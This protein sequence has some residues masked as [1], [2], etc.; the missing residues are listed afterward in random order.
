MK[1]SILAI[2]TFASLSMSAANHLPQNLENNP[3]NVEVANDYSTYLTPSLLQSIIKMNHADLLSVGALD[4]TEVKAI[5]FQP[6]GWDHEF[7]YVQIMVH[8][9]D[10]MESSWVLFYPNEA[11]ELSKDQYTLIDEAD[12]PCQFCKMMSIV[13][14]DEMLILGN[15]SDIHVEGEILSRWMEY[16]FSEMSVWWT[17]D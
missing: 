15:F 13:V 17:E 7:A 3:V 16:D 8:Q 5:K 12:Y 4:K 11:G 2:L 9:G 10:A 14:T 6:D 1:K